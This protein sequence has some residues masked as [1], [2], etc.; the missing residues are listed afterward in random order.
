MA[1]RSHTR[2]MVGSLLVA[3]AIV[4]AVI[5]AVT[6]QLGPTSVA[7]LDAREEARELRQERIEEAREALEERREE[8]A[9]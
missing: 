5:V 2:Q 6:L 9:E 1:E 7:E 8:A 4:A 3:L